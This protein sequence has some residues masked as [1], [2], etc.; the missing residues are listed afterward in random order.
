MHGGKGWGSHTK[1]PC[2]QCLCIAT[3]RQAHPFQQQGLLHWTFGCCPSE[4]DPSSSKLIFKCVMSH[5]LSVPSA[6]AGRP[7]YSL[8][9]K[10]VMVPRQRGE[11]GAGSA[12]MAAAAPGSGEGSDCCCIARPEWGR[13]VAFGSSAKAERLLAAAAR[14]RRAEEMA[15]MAEVNQVAAAGATACAG[16]VG[17]H[18]T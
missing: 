6:T 11:G 3:G 10:L 7:R 13:P 5:R 14:K 16:T 12:G 1:P 4:R 15:E 18:L 17:G 8:V 9:F 2:C